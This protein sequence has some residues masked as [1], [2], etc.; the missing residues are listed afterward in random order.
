MAN[1]ERHYAPSATETE[2]TGQMT[3]TAALTR[4]SMVAPKE[5][6]TLQIGSF[7]HLPADLVRQIENWVMEFE[8]TDSA[9]R[10]SAPWK[11]A[12]LY[13]SGLALGGWQLWEHAS[14]AWIGT[15]ALLSAMVTGSFSAWWV[16]EKKRWALVY[17]LYRYLSDDVSWKVRLSIC[18][19]VWRH[20]RSWSHYAALKAARGEPVET[21]LENGFLRQLAAG[22]EPESVDAHAHA[23]ER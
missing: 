3:S 10:D 5:T 12:T 2:T 9:L 19:Q 22:N 14:V 23:H 7:E 11:T 8:P 18:G 16:T 15:A 6:E 4:L 21:Q 1:D 17:G 13:F 20:R